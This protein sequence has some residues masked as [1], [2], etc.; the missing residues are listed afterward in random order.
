[1]A[2][3]NNSFLVDLS[4]SIG[5]SYDLKSNVLGSTSTPNSALFNISQIGSI[6]TTGRPIFGV[7]DNASSFATISFSDTGTDVT[8]QFSPGIVFFRTNLI[9]MPSQSIPVKS[10]QDTAGTKLFKFYLD[11][12]DFNLSSTVFNCTITSVSGSIIYVNQLPNVNYLNNFKSVNVNNYLF[13]VASI[14]SSVNAIYLTQDPS[15]YAFAGS[16][17]TLIF[18]PVVKYIT[19]FAVTGS[20]PDVSIPR[21]GIILASAIVNITGS[22]GSLSYTCPLGAEK[23][24]ESYP[25]YSSPSDFFP[26]QASYNAFVISVNNSIK[27]YATVQN[28]DIESKLVNS[29]ISYTNGISSNAVGFDQYW[30]SQPLTPTGIFQ[31]GLGFDGLQKVDFDPR[32]KDFWFFYKGVDLIRT[33][34]IFRGDIYGGNVYIGQS[35]GLFPGSS[36][37]N[38]YVDFTG[39]STINNG[40]YSYGISAVTPSGEYAPT[41]NADSNFFFDKKINNYLSWTAPTV[42]SPLFF[43]VYKNVRQL[44]GFQQ[45]RLTSPF[46]VEYSSLNDAVLANTS[47]TPLGISSSYFAFKIKDSDGRRGIIGGLGFNAFITDPGPLTGIQSCLIVSSGSN[48]ISPYVLITGGGTGAS[49]SIS[50]TAGGGIGSVVVTS[51]GSGYTY[52]PTLTIFDNETNSGGSGAQLLPILSQLNC[53]IYTGT[54]SAPTG[55]TIELLQSIPIAS[56]S[57]SYLMNMPTEKE[58]FIGLNSNTNYWAVFSMNVPYAINANQQIKFRVS[59]GFSTNFA[60][61]NSLPTWNSTVS[62]PSQIIKLGFVDQG[63][64]GNVTSSRGVNLTNDKSAYPARIQIYVPNLNLDTLSYDDVGASVSVVGGAIIST[65]PI[66]NSMLISVLAANSVTGFQ[67]TLSGSLPRGTNRGTSILL[68]EETDLFDSVIDVFVAP[69]LETGVNFVTGTSVI[70]WTIYDTFTVDSLP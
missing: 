27:A 12:N 42:S 25:V 68:G 60:T 33:Y 21:S 20:P 47:S 65:A 28:Y 69:D 9:N 38:S 55:T 45:Q 8:F 56:I 36:T 66:Q 4:Q 62:S 13:G 50:T 16:T 11:Y 1:M 7:Y 52:T 35:L 40:T 6:I 19:T 26:N 70:N 22:V 5:I 51:F 10:D 57:S 61:S 53:G 34:A 58:N 39:N 31:Y 48:Y 23:L 54:S 2:N 30:H 14:D 41:F 32:F 37:L 64:T 24:F 43:H 49:I 67:T 63:S 44:N 46:E 3:V 59:S 17:L 18:Q 15:N 29:F